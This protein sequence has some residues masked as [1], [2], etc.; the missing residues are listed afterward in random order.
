VVDA[1]AA[2]LARFA[3]DAEAVPGI[4]L[5]GANA[6]A[7]LL[8]AQNFCWGAQDSLRRIELGTVDVPQLR[9]RIRIERG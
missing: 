5:E 7:R 4:E 8:L 6:E 3:V 2:Q 1:H 9:L